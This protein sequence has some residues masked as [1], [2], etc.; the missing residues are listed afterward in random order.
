MSE[1]GQNSNKSFGGNKRKQNSEAGSKQKRGRF[2]AND[3]SSLALPTGEWGFLI[4]SDSGCERR[5]RQEMIQLLL[6]VKEKLESQSDN[7]KQDKQTLNGNS[8]E[9]KEAEIA[10]KDAEKVQ[11]KTGEEQQEKTSNEQQANIAQAVEEELKQLKSKEDKLFHYKDIS[12][13]MTFLIMKKKEGVPD[14]IQL[15]S[16]L[17]EEIYE[18]AESKARFCMKLLPI[19]HSCFASMD[20]INKL[21][22][23]VVEQHFKKDD[24]ESRFSIQYDHRFGPEL[25]RMA[26]IDAFAELVPCPP[27]KVDLNNPDITILVQIVK[28]SCGVSVVRNWKKFMK[29]NLREIVRVQNE[30]KS[31]QNEGE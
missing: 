18:K 29:Y 2:V 21:A 13:G 17:M 9:K 25:E 10:E 19:T 12:K 27:Y 8:E 31:S 26:V 20:E 14:P 16:S 6:Q 1:G 15:S 28:N 3:V 7:Q 30:K 24:V 23:T 22:K 5:A 4:S 11:E